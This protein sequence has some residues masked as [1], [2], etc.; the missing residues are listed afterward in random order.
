MI[1]G[2][3]PDAAVGTGTGMG[4]GD[5]ADIS[6]AGATGVPAQRL[7]EQPSPVSGRTLA[8]RLRGANVSVLREVALLPVL[9]ILLVVGA[10]VSPVFFT[11]SNI[12]GVGQQISALGVVV[13]GESL[14]LMIGGMDLSLE[15]TYGLAPMVAAWLILP[16]SSFGNGTKLNPYIGILIL[17]A[18][19]AAL[20]KNGPGTLTIDNSGTY[21]GGT[22]VN[23]GV[24]QASNPTGS[25]TGSGAVSVTGS[26]ILRGT[27]IIGGPVQNDGTVKPGGT[28]GTLTIQNTYSQGTGGSL[29][30]LV[31]GPA[32]TNH[33]RLS[34]TD[35]ATLSGRS[36]R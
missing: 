4:A 31:G 32:D 19:G 28:V 1:S 8:D 17:L 21:S 2:S 22:S 13:V 20:V 35:A 26:G 24:L 30:I 23:A 16:I 3:T 12:A 10:F 34:V 7:S 25:A 5:T 27:G 33:T 6:D 15:S 9:A 29:S 18:V 36:A 11:V 14:I